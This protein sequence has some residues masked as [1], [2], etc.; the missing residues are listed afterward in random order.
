MILDSIGITSTGMASLGTSI[1]GVI[2][3]K[4]LA[5][6]NNVLGDPG[7]IYLSNAL[8]YN[9][10]LQFLDLSKNQFTHVSA[11]YLASVLT[12]LSLLKVLKIG[13][14]SIKDEGFSIIIKAVTYNLEELDI[15]NIEISAVGLAKLCECLLSLKK[16]EYLNLDYNNINQK[17]STM[18]ID[19][20]PRLALKHLSLIGCDVSSHRKALSLAQNCTEVLI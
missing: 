7:I 13:E 12:Q 6:G 4:I 9:K 15:N 1:S 20:L 14:N 8:H 5:L 2:N 10:Q 17:S 3:L 16:L 18:L 19:I 11:C